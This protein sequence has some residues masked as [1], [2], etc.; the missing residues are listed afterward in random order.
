MEIKGPLLGDEFPA[1]CG[2]GCVLAAVAL[3]I[4]GGVLVEL[5]RALC[6]R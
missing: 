2:C 1:N 5:I 4:C 6:C 3:L